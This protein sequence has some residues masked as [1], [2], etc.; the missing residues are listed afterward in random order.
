[1]SRVCLR[2]VALPSAVSRKHGGD[3]KADKLDNRAS[4]LRT[5]TVKSRSGPLQHHGGPLPYGRGS[6]ASNQSRASN[7]SDRNA[8]IGSIR[9]ARR[10]GKYPATADTI[11]RMLDDKA[12]VT[13]SSMV[14]P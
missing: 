13:G 3:S 5:A 12:M 7:Y 1:M 6:E 4:D 10:A 11:S 9:E 2:P 14:T 8:T